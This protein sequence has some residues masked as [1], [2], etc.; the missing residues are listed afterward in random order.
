MPPEIREEMAERT[1]WGTLLTPDLLEPKAPP[2]PGP[3]DT[4][5]LIRPPEW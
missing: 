2:L 5:P 4:G 3:E 1:N